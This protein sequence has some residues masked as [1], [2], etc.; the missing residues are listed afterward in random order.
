M[1][2]F[3]GVGVG[4]PIVSS[5]AIQIRVGVPIQIHAVCIPALAC[6]E[7]V[8]VHR[9][10][11]PE[12]CVLRYLIWMRLVVSQKALDQEHGVCLVCSMDVA[13]ERHL[14]LAAANSMSGDWAALY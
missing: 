1:L 13:Y 11:E 4:R 7:A 9:G 10:D 8:G 5:T 12:T 2:A 14:D 3:R 6:F